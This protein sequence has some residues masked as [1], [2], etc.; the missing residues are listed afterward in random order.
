MNISIVQVVNRSIVEAMVDDCMPYLA[1]ASRRNGKLVVVAQN[2]APIDLGLLKKR[3][4]SE[5]S[6]DF[7]VSVDLFQ[8]TLL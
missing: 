1:V 5:S 7:D 3:L 4:A 8:F 6:L 2:V